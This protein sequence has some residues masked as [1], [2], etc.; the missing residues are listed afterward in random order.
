MKNLLIGL[1]Y[2]WFDLWLKI[3]SWSAKTK[4]LVWDRN[5]NKFCGP[6]NWNSNAM[7]GMSHEQRITYTMGFNERR[8]IAHER[9]LVSM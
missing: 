3:E 7:L 5:I 1:R 9:D 8:R 4:W 2:F 6:L